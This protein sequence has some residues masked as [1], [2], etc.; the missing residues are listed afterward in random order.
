MVRFIFSPMNKCRWNIMI[1]VL[2]KNVIV[3]YGNSYQSLQ[4]T[5]LF[6][7]F[8]FR[9]MTSHTRKKRKVLLVY[10]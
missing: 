5:Y 4:F 2:K 1:I 3:D 8:S 10:S 9:V 7:A 6:K